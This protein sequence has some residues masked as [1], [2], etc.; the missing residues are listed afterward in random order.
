VHVATLR[1][2]AAYAPA[3][4]AYWANEV[5][6]L[7]SSGRRPPIGAGFTAFI[8]A[9]SV[10]RAAS[11]HLERE[12]AEGRTNPY[13][14]HPSL[15]ERIAALERFPPGEPDDSAPAEALVRDPGTLEAAQA[16][17]LFGRDAGAMRPVDWDAVG[18]EV[19]LE[20]ARRLVAAHGEL[21]G[22]ASAGELDGLVDRL[23][24]V[25]SD[26]QQREPDLEVEHARDFAAALISDALLVALHENGWAVEA[27]PAEPV[28]CRRGDSRV[29]PHAVVHDLREGR[30]TGEQWRDRAA[31]LGIARLALSM[32]V[33][34]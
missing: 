24:R 4:D 28:M 27:P 31:D 14:S 2:V 16:V 13:D 5:A 21:V 10:D 9:D 30:L 26:L 7:L 20:R 3:F 8:R 29:A 1:R 33:A 23:G 18:T 12:L 15:A 11:E 25:A 6:P 19:Y 32:G 34:P 17:H 22:D